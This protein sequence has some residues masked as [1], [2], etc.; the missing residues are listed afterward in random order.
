MQCTESVTA[1]AVSSVESSH[2][3]EVFLF[4]C[5]LSQ[6]I[7]LFSSEY[8]E[9][10]KL[11]LTGPNNSILK[12]KVVLALSKTSYLW[13]NRPFNHRMEI[14]DQEKADVTMLTQ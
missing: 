1:C 13:C 4:G 12:T 5:C 8:S 2:Y 6:L 14:N 7:L 3:Y 11:Q 9:K 10:N